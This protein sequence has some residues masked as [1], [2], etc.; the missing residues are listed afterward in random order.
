MIA[1]E[2]IGFTHEINPIGGTISRVSIIGNRYSLFL[3]DGLHI[4]IQVKVVTIE[5]INQKIIAL[6]RL[7]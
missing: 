2:I 5:A 1:D 7:P 3:G 6:D 4:T